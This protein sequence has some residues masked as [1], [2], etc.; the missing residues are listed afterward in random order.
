[1]GSY[2]DGL[3][4]TATGFRSGGNQHVLG[5]NLSASY[6]L[7]GGEG[8]AFIHQPGTAPNSTVFD[9][10]VHVDAALNQFNA[11]PGQ[12]YEA[13]A[14]LNAYRCTGVVGI[15]WLTWNGTYISETAGNG[16]TIQSAVT[17]LNELQQSVV[18]STAP[19]N[20]A[21]GTVYIRAITNGQADPYLFFT[22]VF[23]GEASAAQ[24]TPSP[25]SPGTGISQIT[26]S[27]VSTYIASAAIGSAQIADAAIT[28]AKIGD[29]QITNAKIGDAAI[30]TAKIGDAAI[31][32]AKIGDAQITNAKIGTAAVDTLKI[33]GQAVTIPVSAYTAGS[34]GGGNIQSASITSTGAPIFVIA[35]YAWT[36]D[37][38][39]RGVRTRVLRNGVE[40]YDSGQVVAARGSG[41]LNSVSFRDTPG[42]GPHTYTVQVSAFS[43]DGNSGGTISVFARSVLLL[44]VKR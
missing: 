35:S 12:R 22:R 19:E 28:T 39:N 9:A 13:H 25:W 31:T 14:L 44:E 20:A 6:Q 40:V 24:T 7:T 34:S 38:N 10:S 29:A 36:G 1:M 18:F 16:I 27:N 41:G 26:A 17:T 23:L 11:R 2:R 4:G 37:D 32:T 8:L 33:A 5:R 15:V 21:R 42:V 3:I 30:T 43:Y